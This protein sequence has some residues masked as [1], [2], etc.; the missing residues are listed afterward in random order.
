MERY[1]RDNRDLKAI[2]AAIPN[3]K[4]GLPND[5]ASAVAYLASDEAHY[6]TGDVMFVDG[7]VT[8]NMG[9]ND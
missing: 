6:V 5:V 7:G 3:K 2:Q 4:L 9:V 8:A 1:D